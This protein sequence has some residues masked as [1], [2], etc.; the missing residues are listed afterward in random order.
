MGTSYRCFDLILEGMIPLD[1]GISPTSVVSTQIC[2]DADTSKGRKKGDG[3]RR[4]KEKPLTGVAIATRNAAIS[5]WKNDVKKLERKQEELKMRSQKVE[6]MKRG[7][8]AGAKLSKRDCAL[9]GME[10][11]IQWELREVLSQLEELNLSQA[12]AIR[13]Y[14]GRS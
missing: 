11:D 2:S 6:H 9:L 7:V 8:K 4:S 12:D 10:D 14:T 13:M 3:N 1:I 5:N